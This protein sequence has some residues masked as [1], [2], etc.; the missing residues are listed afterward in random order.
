MMYINSFLTEL[1]KKID[2]VG[3]QLKEFESKMDKI[4]NVKNILT[5]KTL[6]DIDSLTGEDL[7]LL[8]KDDFLEILETF[9][10]DNAE[11]TL[12]IFFN[13]S[14][15][16]KVN[17]KLI[18]DGEVD[19]SEKDITNYIKWLEGQVRF[20]KEYINDFNLNNK[21]YYNSLKIS[22]SLYKKYIGY[23]KN[24]KLIKPIYN[25]EEFNEVIK[26]SGIITSD[27]WQ[28]LKYVG[29]KNIEFQKKNE[30]NKK[31]VIEY[32]DEEI[33]SF[34]EA[35]L[36]R[37]KKLIESITD[38][39]INTSLEMLDY[40]EEEIKDKGITESDI[41]LY[42]KVPIVDTMNKMYLETKEMLKEEL[43]EDAFKIEKNLKQLLSLV[44]SYNVIKKIESQEGLNV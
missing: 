6:K 40:D 38:D 17:Q 22:D 32:S 16:L 21:E 13:A 39:L 44:D 28:L 23:F 37:E 43:D 29:E 11:E 15:A 24:N 4:N 26:K 20:I 2:T 34:V 36:I 10:V 19:V 25:I 7:V 41:T 9:K 1:S 30:A 12:K 42:Q 35:I 3:E 18:S 8:S 31:E 27:K 14:V 5:L 33:I